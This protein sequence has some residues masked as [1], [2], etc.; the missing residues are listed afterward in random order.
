MKL[1]LVARR[2]PPDVRSGTETVF[3]NLYAQARQHH[4]A[5]L[6]VGF[7]SARDQVPDEARAVDLRGLPPGVSHAKMLAAAAEEARR[8][9]P[10]VVLSNSIE[11]VLTTHPTVVIVHDLNFGKAGG[12]PTQPGPTRGA[13]ARARELLYRVQCRRAAAVVVVSEATR[14]ALA[15]IGVRER[16]Q[17]VHNGVDLARFGVVPP[18]GGPVVR[19][20]VPG[21]VLPGKG[22]HVALDALGR[23]RPDQRKGAELAVVGALADPIYGDKLKIQ[24]FKLPV[25]FEFDVPDLVPHYQA[26]DVVL[27]PTLME[28]GFG[29]AAIEG[30][31]AGRPVVW[32]EQPAVR[33]ATGGVGL[34]IP[35]DDPDALRAAMLRLMADPALRA[36]LGQEGRARA[37]ALSWE[38]AWAGYERVLSGLAAAR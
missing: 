6:V 38:A 35:R 10:D 16:V 13:G 31:A 26:A 5:R 27:F 3:A 28:E 20:L 7:R 32:T 1:L 4:D 12:T 14:E 9:G 8:F 15:R 36:Q 33:E 25:H 34:A 18:P 2:Y 30:M 22:Q 17:V 23:M 24:A 37:L 11:I 21:R 29:F 19:F